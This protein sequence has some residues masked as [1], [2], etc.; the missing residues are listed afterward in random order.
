[1]SAAI[2][3]VKSFTDVPYQNDDNPKHTLDLYLPVFDTDSDDD[4]QQTP[5]ENAKA[6]EAKPTDSGNTPLTKS[7]SSPS[8]LL[9]YIHGGAWRTGDKSEYVYLGQQFAQMGLPTAV[10]NY[11]LSPKIET[12]D[13]KAKKGDEEKQ[14]QSSDG[15]SSETEKTS[16]QPADPL[17]H[18]SHLQDCIQALRWLRYDSESHFGYLPTHIYL[19]GHSAGG[20]LS[21]LLVLEPKWLEEVGGPELYQSVVGVIGVEGIYNIPKLIKTWPAYIDFIEGAFGK[22]E[23]GLWKDA[24]PQYKSLSAKGRVLPSYLVIHSLEDELVD[25]PQAEEYVQHLKGMEPTRSG[26]AVALNTECKGKHFE[27]LREKGFFDAV[28]AFVK[29]SDERL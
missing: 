15:K 12:A 21:G 17:Q 5:A 20:Q 6:S 13:A 29:R 22:E 3:T 19:C 11:R 28:F 18:P 10:I 9:V 16:S 14:Q 1:M 4:E 25:L 27:M 24:S 8:P 7:T 23:E 26:L 2:I